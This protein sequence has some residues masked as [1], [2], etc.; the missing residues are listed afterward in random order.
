MKHVGLDV[1][2]GSVCFVVRDESGKITSDVYPSVFG[3]Y[4]EKDSIAIGGSTA[5]KV[6]RVF[7]LGDSRYVLGYEDLKKASAKAISAYDRDDRIS[8]KEFRNLTYLALMDAATRDGSHGI[9]EVTLGVGV[10]SEDFRQSVIEKIK[11]WFGT[12][13]TGSVNGNQV[14]IVVKHV[15]ILS[16]PVS[17]LIN[18]YLDDNGFVQDEAVEDGRYL[19]IDCGSGTMDMTELNGLAIVRQVSYPLGMNDVYMGLLDV[20][21][22]KTKLRPSMYDIEYQIRK[23]TGSKEKVYVSG[24][25]SVDLT[26]DYERI[27]S[28]IATQ[29]IS[30]VT[31]EFPDRADIDRIFLAGG[32]GQAMAPY[33]LNAI[34]GLELCEEP[35]LA[36]ARG[37]YKYV[38]SLTGA[39]TE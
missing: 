35:Q 22:S 37:L 25:Y 8:R 1:G 32:T 23:H 18:Q 7:T 21:R 14:V 3:V 27:V 24:R 10:P 11:D 30:A 15:E 16:Q 2:N 33:L 19:I 36:I 17:A 13:V 20:V 26:E 4:E 12:P 9:I 6:N 28:S 5:K 29:M 38:V 34:D 39:E 31:S